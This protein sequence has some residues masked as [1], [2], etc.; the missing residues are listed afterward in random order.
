MVKCCICY[1]TDKGYLFPTLVSA[2]QA[3]RNVSPGKADVAIF[4]FGA[5][6][7]AQAIF[8]RICLDEGIRF[9]PVDFDMI[10]GAPA[11]LARLFLDRFVPAEYEQLLYIDGDTQI[12]RSLDQLVDVDVPTGSFMA[13]DDPM[14]FAARGKGGNSREISEH[15][16]SIGFKDFESHSYFN[17]GVLRINREGW[18]EIGIE[19]WRLF[20]QA[21]KTSRFPDQ[22]VLNLIG[23]ARRIPISLAWNFPIFMLNSRVE[24]VIAPCIYH[25]MSNP[26]P[27]HGPF[28]PWTDKAYRPYFDTLSKY[29]ETAPY[30]ATLPMA[31]QL[32]YH[33]QQRYKKVIE[34]FTWGLSN[35]RE[36]I[37]NYERR[38]SSTTLGQSRQAVGFSGL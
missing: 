12:S 37:L 16:A 13:V 14:V 7:A 8:S 28:P 23:A 34:T 20:R 38:L 15:F 35:K 21:D 19:A 2:A 25:F 1:T 33:L 27:W 26:K 3:R 31:T 4:S 18:A 17:T 22:D 29:P 9:F 24:Q 10:D 11:M 32:R 5:D 30:C 6:E 36:H